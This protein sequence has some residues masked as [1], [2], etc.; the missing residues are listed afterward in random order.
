MA[1]VCICIAL[2]LLSIHSWGQTK[3]DTLKRQLL[4]LP[5]DT[6][7]VIALNDLAFLYYNIDPD[8]AALFASE[9]SQIATR[10]NYKKGIATSLLRIGAINSIKG[11]VVAAIS[12]YEKCIALAD[13]IR[14]TNLLSRAFLNMGITSVDLDND[15]KAL[16]YYK[17][18]RQGFESIGNKPM[19]RTVEMN[20]GS[21]YLNLNDYENAD[22]YLKSSFREGEDGHPYFGLL[23]INL[24][25]LRIK[26][27]M[28]AEAD[29]LLALAWKNLSN[30]TNTNH[31]G[32]AQLVYARYYMAIDSLQMALEHG[33]LALTYIRRV[34]YLTEAYETLA[35]IEKKRGNIPM[36]YKYQNLQIFYKDSV[37]SVLSKNRA[38]L[39]E[40]QDMERLRSIQKTEFD[41]QQTKEY[42]E[43][44]IFFGSILLFTIITLALGYSIQQKQRTNKKLTEINKEVTSKNNELELNKAELTEVNKELQTRESELNAANE[45]LTQHQEEIAAQ[46]DAIAI[47][48]T[49]LQQANEL[50]AIQNLRISQENETLEKAVKERTKELVEYNQ[51]LEQFAFVTAHNLRAPVARILGLGNLL[52][53]KNSSVHER[54]DIMNRMITTTTELDFVIHD[55]NKILEVRKNNTDTYSIVNFAEELSKIQGNLKTEIDH[56]EAIIESD[57]SAYPT[58]YSIRPYIDSILYNLIGNALKYR[59]PNRKPLIKIKTTFRRNFILLTIA[60]NGIGFNVEANSSK[61]FRLY[62]RFHDHVEGRGIG[63]FLVKTQVVALNGKITVDSTIDKGTTFTIIF[64]EPK[65]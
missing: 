6:S 33:L 54:E 55:L 53:L 12:Y 44:I 9:A 26:Q 23:L 17:R 48:N 29:S 20:M 64:R 28:Y 52:R 47:Q 63:L 14:D 51:Q 19:S 13:S 59:H 31:K 61:L 65:A 7:R 3:A 16:E 60:D 39:F 24:A 25:S 57:F 1:K 37:Q 41:L 8:S 46:Y 56:A 62:S 18:A 30:T 36:A 58:L 32:E 49:K 45:E 5:N 2:L 4:T 10:L 50:I 11:D 38:R 22:R 40:I 27:Q 43:R 34:S 21:A 15:F 42:N 35:A